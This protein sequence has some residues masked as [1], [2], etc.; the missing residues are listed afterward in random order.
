MVEARGTF[1]STAPDTGVCNED[2]RVDGTDPKLNLSNRKISN[3]VRET[4]TVIGLSLHHQN[5]FAAAQ[6]DRFRDAVYSLK[7]GLRF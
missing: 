2:C 6:V 3:S 4:H 5:L 1:K 7:V